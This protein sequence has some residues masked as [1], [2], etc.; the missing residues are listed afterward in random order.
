LICSI[1][2]FHLFPQKE[3]H[4]NRFLFALFVCFLFGATAEA[5]RCSRAAARQARH[6]ARGSC[7]QATCATAT[8]IPAM[9][10]RK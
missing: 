5:S 10:M 3:F 2:L 7:A 1:D 9:E 8:V 4:M 6:Q